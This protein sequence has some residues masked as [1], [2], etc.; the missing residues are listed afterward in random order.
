MHS[1]WCIYWVLSMAFVGNY[2]SFPCATVRSCVFPEVPVSSSALSMH[3]NWNL[4]DII[5]RFHVIMCVHFELELEF[6]VDSQI[7]CVLNVITSN[8]PY[9][10]VSYGYKWALECPIIHILFPGI[11][12]WMPYYL[13]HKSPM[14]N[15]NTIFNCKYAQLLLNAVLLRNWS[16]SCGG[17]YPIL[18]LSFQHQTRNPFYPF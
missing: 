10:G 1:F 9:S 2:T 7:L 8:R 17:Y 14:W 16:I 13:Y 11:G 15:L 6:V 4:L 5:W 3:P 18:V 12:I